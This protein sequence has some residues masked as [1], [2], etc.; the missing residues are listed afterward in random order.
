MKVLT[1]QCL[2]NQPKVHKANGKRTSLEKSV[3]IGKFNKLLLTAK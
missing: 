1:I 3:E 2:A